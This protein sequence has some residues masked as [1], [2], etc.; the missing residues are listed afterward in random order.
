MSGNHENQEEQQA[1][2]HAAD[3]HDGADGVGAIETL[4]SVEHVGTRSPAAEQRHQ[5]HARCRNQHED[6]ADFAVHF[7]VLGAIPLARSGDFVC[8]WFLLKNQ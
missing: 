4:G 1:H 7:K 5:T 3:G 6:S 8:H 2:A